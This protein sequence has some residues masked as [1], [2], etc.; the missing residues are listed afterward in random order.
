MTVTQSELGEYLERLAGKGEVV[1]YTDLYDHFQIPAKDHLTGA[2]P[3]PAMLARTIQDDRRANRPFRASFVVTK[4]EGHDR[5]E[6]VPAD[7]YFVALCELKEA[8]WPRTQTEKQ[9]L[10]A[11]ELKAA[12]VYYGHKRPL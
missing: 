6:W 9:D 12:F 11:S 1:C 5:S 3:M 8:P 7:P 10:Y 4:D 2:N